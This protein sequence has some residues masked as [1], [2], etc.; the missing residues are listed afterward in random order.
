M[1]LKGLSLRIRPVSFE[2]PIK[3]CEIGFCLERV[4]CKHRPRVW[5]LTVRVRRVPALG[6]LRVGRAGVCL[7]A[8][9]KR[10]VEKEAL[11]T[12]NGVLILG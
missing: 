3:N 5:M 8:Q 11:T 9:S 4:H 6:V 7:V 10:K 12:G 2:Q 1:S